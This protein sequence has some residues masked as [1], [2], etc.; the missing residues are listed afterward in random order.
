MK[1]KNKVAAV[2]VSIALAVLFSLLML[3]P[4][5]SLSQT[6][7]PPKGEPIVIGYVGQVASPGTKPCMDIQQM[8]VDEINAAGGIL[9]RP[10]KYIVQ[11]GKGDTSLSV[12]AARKL[13]IEDKATFVSVEGRSEICLAVQEN[14]GNLFKEYPHILVFNGPMGSELTARIIDEA[15]KYDFCFRDWDPEP[16]HYAQT[17]YIME[18]TWKKDLGVK[19]IAI[20]WE[21]LAWTT[22]WRK[23]IDYINLPTWEK[24]AESVGLKVVYSKAVK[25]RGT[26]YMP[27]LQ[28]IA[29]KK[30]DLIFFVSSWFTDTDAFAKQWADSAAKDIYVSLYGGVAQTRAF[31]SMT[32]GKALG[33]FSSFTDLDVPVTSKTLPLMEKA[34]K[35]NIPMQIHVHIAYADIYHFKAAIEAA[36]GTNDIK[37]LIKAMEE[38]ETEYSLGKVKY[39]TQKVKPFYHSRVRVNPK[40]PWKTIPGYYYQLLI[41]FQEGGKI[42]YLNESC[43]E[44]EKAM[45]KFI[46][47]KAVK[48]PAQLRKIQAGGR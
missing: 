1:K 22:E 37:K 41:Q 9:G 10:V 14:S 48:T 13:I 17:K 28:E 29:N 7:A 19:K 33:I 36:G 21:D 15:P 46:N 45:A 35:R 6:K 23:G 18:K 26:M 12:E 40:D 3:W 34:I 4:S 30:A 5:A 16:A 2:A 38:V 11:D 25:P 20:L 39:E 43:P 8:A 42:V 27:I 47:P 32:G 44:N 31:W 24:L